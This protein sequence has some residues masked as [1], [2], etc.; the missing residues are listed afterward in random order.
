MALKHWLQRTSAVSH[1]VG[2]DLP[3]AH[4]Q[5]S[6]RPQRLTTYGTRQPINSRPDWTDS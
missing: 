1:T 5:S 6:V 4:P 2:R 3:S